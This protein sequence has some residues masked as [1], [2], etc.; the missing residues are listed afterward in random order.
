MARCSMLSSSSSFAWRAL[1]AW[2]YPADWAGS[3]AAA[4]FLECMRRRYTGQSLRRAT[5]V[6]VACGV[7]CEGV[8][9]AART[10]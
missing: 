2:C 9:C 4:A 6:G 10:G 3:P 1:P 5:Q 8:N 7:G